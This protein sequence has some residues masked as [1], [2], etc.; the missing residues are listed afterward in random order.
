MELYQKFLQKLPAFLQLKLLHAVDRIAKNDLKGLDIKAL[1]G[2]RDFF[3]CRIG[4]LRIIF[5]KK[6]GMNIVRDIRF[7][8]G[9]YK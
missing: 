1:Q 5:E 3:R 7:R 4:K 2:N 6:E 9:A 8:G